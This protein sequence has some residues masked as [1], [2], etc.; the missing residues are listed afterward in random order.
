MA[1]FSGCGKRGGINQPSYEKLL[2]FRLHRGH[3]DYLL[4][5]NITIYTEIKTELA[6]LLEG[7]E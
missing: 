1:T 6:K 4:L 3:S 7:G 2:T 5:N